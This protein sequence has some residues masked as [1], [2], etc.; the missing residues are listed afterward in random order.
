MYTVWKRGH[1]NLTDLS[2]SSLSGAYGTGAGSSL[3]LAWHRHPLAARYGPR[4]LLALRTPL[5]NTMGAA[6][7]K[8]HGTPAN[9][10]RT[11]VA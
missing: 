10:S 1:A 4:P 2:L 9:P 11:H 7:G 5:P 6:L 8:R 3:D